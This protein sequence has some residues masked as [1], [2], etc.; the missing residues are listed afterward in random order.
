MADKDVK[1][2]IRLEYENGKTMQFLA[3][4]YG[5]KLGTIKTWS[6]TQKWIKKKPNEKTKPKRKP[7]S[8]KVKPNQKIEK[9]NNVEIELKKDILNEMP[10]Q[11]VMDKYG[12][13]K[14]A[15][16]VKKKS[17]SE[18][19]L[20]RSEMYLRKASEFAYP[21]AQELLQKIKIKKRNILLGGLQSISLDTLNK[22]EQ[23]T[24][25]K[26]LANITKIENEIMK[27]LG[28]VSIYKQIETDAQINDIDIQKEKLEIEKVKVKELINSTNDESVTII[29]DITGE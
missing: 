28:I 15:Y 29:D 24:L 1:E 6:F 27:D 21:D 18:L 17:I 13:K 9:S 8:N 16:Y 2:I 23:E 7:K 25:S 11:E 4:K 20:E 12:I 14:S 10:R 22:S 26:A 5:V 19:I 3:D